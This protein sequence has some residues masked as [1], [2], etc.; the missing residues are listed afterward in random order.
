MVSDTILALF[1]FGYPVDDSGTVAFVKNRF[2]IPLSPKLLYIGACN[3]VTLL[4]EDGVTRRKKA[5]YS[6]PGADDTYLRPKAGQRFAPRQIAMCELPDAAWLSWIH[7][8]DAHDH[9]VVARKDGA[10]NVL[11]ELAGG[12]RHRFGKPALM[13]TDASAPDVF[14]AV[15]AGGSLGVRRYGIHR[16]RWRCTEKLPT[17][18]LSI[19]HMDAVSAPD[20]AVHL[21]YAGV[22]EDCVGLALYSR[23]MRGERWGTERRHALGGASLN[24]PK[25]A[26]DGRG[27]V[28]LVADAYRD[29]RYEIMWKTLWGGPA[30][31]WQRLSRTT[32]WSLFPS[33]VCDHEGRLWVSWLRQVPVRREDVMGLWQEAR[34]ARRIGRRWEEVSGS[35]GDAAAHLNF[36]LLPIRRYFGYDG[37]RRYPRLAATDDGAVWLVWEQQRDEKEIWDNVANGFFCGKRY[38]RGKWWK[39]VTLVDGG[40]CHT[41]DEKHLHAADSFSIAAKSGHRR[42]GDD[43]VLRRVDMNAAASAELPPASRWKAWKAQALPIRTRPARPRSGEYRL[44]WGDLHCH[45]V[46]S[47]DAE[48]EPDEL[49]HFARDLAGLD[50]VCVMDNDFYPQKALLDSEVTYTAD[51]ARALTRD[52]RF[53]AFSGFEWTYHGP[54]PAQSFNHRIVLFTG[55]SPRVFRRNERAGGSERAFVEN[56]RKTAFISIPHHAHWRLTGIPNECCVEVTSA[57]GPCILDAPTVH[58]ALA[59]GHRFGFLGNTDSHRFMPGLSGALTGLYAK[60][61]SRDG[62]IDALRAR[63]CFATTGN[64]TAI[65]FRVNG[66]MMGQEINADAAPVLSWRV[67]PHASLEKIEI[68]RDGEVAFSSHAATSAW[69]DT[70]ARAGDHW[71]YLRVKEKGVHKRYPHN[72]APAWGKWAW[73]SPVWVDVK[74]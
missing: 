4:E 33:I 44:L 8:E 19:Y 71:Y 58:D 2:F 63:R 1:A 72:V 42:S 54:D 46:F 45:S 66:A 41:F 20:G 26:V 36:G 64:R 68:V 57:W 50:F 34:V 32:G 14:C 62:I 56:V 24:R 22:S 17:R 47:P 9:L 10:R 39:T 40:N 53:V 5:V 60:E 70:A 11:C 55:G 7:Y 35:R 13:A 15:K 73:S 12:P 25:L 74:S 18:C 16:G 48:G 21:A 52:G 65:D 29:Q 37:L 51:L 49:Y 59:N 31:K 6:S 30:H 67:A 3:N 43:F 27:E 69:T 23:T 38:A 28:V 61:L